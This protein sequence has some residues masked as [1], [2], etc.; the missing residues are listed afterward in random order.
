MAVRR[1]QGA[2]D[3]TGCQSVVPQ[4]FRIKFDADLSPL[5]TDELSLD[6]GESDLEEGEW[7]DGDEALVCTV[8]YE[9]QQVQMET[10]EGIALPPV[11]YLNDEGSRRRYGNVAMLM[12]HVGPVRVCDYDAALHGPWGSGSVGSRTEGGRSDGVVPPQAAMVV[13]SHAEA[14]GGTRGE[15]AVGSRKPYR[16]WRRR[17]CVAENARWGRRA[18]V[19]ALRVGAAADGER[20]DLVRATLDARAAAS[21]QAGAE[22]RQARAL[23]RKAARKALRAAEVEQRLAEERRNLEARSRHRPSESQGAGAQVLVDVRSASMVDIDAATEAQ[24]GSSDRGGISAVGAG[25]RICVRAHGPW[26]RARFRWA[27]EGACV[28]ASWRW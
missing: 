12:T 1:L 13:E 25:E 23:E 24:A 19:W 28:A 21:L 22:D 7:L 16:W 3:G 18:E 17:A 4:T 11:R 26:V 6:Q 15:T 2:K 20:R 8:V 5:A 10:S 27:V 14:R 9:Y